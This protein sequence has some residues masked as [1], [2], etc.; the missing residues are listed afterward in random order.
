MLIDNFVKSNNYSISVVCPFHRNEDTIVRAAKSIFTQT[1]IPN[2]VIFVN[3]NSPD[4]SLDKLVEFISSC[5]LKFSIQVISITHSGPGHARNIGIQRCTSKWISFLDADDYWMPDK[6]K[7]VVE[8]I[9]ERKNINFIAHDEFT[10]KDNYKITNSRLSKY[11][12]NKIPL[13]YQLFNRNFLSTSSCTISK[14]L[15]E[16]FL[17]DPT[18]SSSQDY[19]LWLALSYKMELMYISEPLTFYDTSL[20][21]SITNNFQIKRFMNLI[22]VLFRYSRNVSFVRFSFVLIK[23]FLAFCYSF[24]HK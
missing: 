2:E 1:L 10:Q 12:K 18:L 24:L 11:F 5:H 6:L 16:Q 13:S 19:E 17:F 14:S 15:L 22:I 21:T 20:K 23:H 8:G 3:D 7:F 4:N 9:N